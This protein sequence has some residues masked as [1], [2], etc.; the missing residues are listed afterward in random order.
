[1]KDL[2]SIIIP[3]YNQADKTVRAIESCLKQTYSCEVI[4]I[5]DGST[6]DTHEKLKSYFKVPNF[7]YF[8]QLNAGASNAR[9][10]GIKI[11]TGEYI[12]FLDCDDYYDHDKIERS[13]YFMKATG[14]KMCHTSAYFINKPCIHIGFDGQEYDPTGYWEYK[15]K[16]KAL[17]NLLF[18]NYICNSTVVMD[19]FVID[20]VGDYDES[21][22]IA[23]DWDMWLR[24]E[25]RFCIGYLPYALTAKDGGTYE[26]V[27]S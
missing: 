7:W 16:I 17:G 23:A 4:V 8:R 22:F 27:Y 24:I 2:C 25:E 12:A 5:D 14:H 11:A 9:N 21:L 15:P 26:P 18:R 6:D 19:R 20:K 13:I 3:A 10:A 1:M